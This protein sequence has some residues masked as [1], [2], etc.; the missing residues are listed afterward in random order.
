[1]PRFNELPGFRSTKG[2]AAA[3]L[4][5]C[6]WLASVASAN[7]TFIFPRVQFLWPPWGTY[8]ADVQHTGLSHYPAKALQ[9]VLWSYDIDPQQP[10][11]Q[12]VLAHYGSPV[13]TPANTVIFPVTT[14]LATSYEFR[15]V[16]GATGNTIWF[17]DTDYILPPCD[18]TPPVEGSVINRAGYAMPG[19]G[20]SI[21]YRANADQGASPTKQI[22][23]YGQA[24]HDANQAW[25]DANIKINTPI[26][27]DP[28]GNMWF[29][30]YV[31]GSN[32]TVTPT[33]PAGFPNLGRG[34]LARINTA[35]VGT[36]ISAT[37]AAGD[38]TVNF[39]ATACAP[40]L[41]ND[42]RSVYMGFVR[43]YNNS[44]GYLVKFDARTLAVQARAQPVSPHINP[45]T[46]QPYNVGFIVDSSA[47]PMVGPDG[48]VYMGVFGLGG[49]SADYRESH[50]WMLHYDADLNPKGAIG[51]FGW[52]DTA[53][54][55]PSSIVPQYTGTSPYLILT[56]YNNYKWSDFWTTPV[57][58]G[59]DGLNT[60]A[61]LDPFDPS[62]TDR[63]TGVSSMNP[64]LLV[65]GITPDDPAVPGSV[66]EW[67][68]NSAAI[69]P[70]NKTAIVNSEDG[71]CY[72][73]DFTSNTLQP[74]SLSGTGILL[75]SPTGEAYTP[76]VIGPNGTVY[77]I[78]DHKLYAIGPLP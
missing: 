38:T 35:N 41:S 69:D 58:P 54:I 11:G 30:Y 45:S 8:G 37:D 23:F 77:A 60:V 52:D 53:T 71:H 73:W 68:I 55:V 40:V 25:A 34:G 72:T 1:M 16:D 21:Y 2:A 5:F 75:N 49:F 6:L 70:F 9:Q 46:G 27:A 26:L 39:A 33:Y 28:R 56:K 31:G 78:N 24:N 47:C 17:F 10:A 13:I 42:V 66:R 29:G 48:D 15:A 43:A 4:A 50:G 65:Y 76:T 74:V 63:Q 36:W 19:V 64:V 44:T 67:C 3:C 14:Q 22:F 7:A 32:P 61:L 62:G 59:A 12:E 18:W 51:A 20:G 57:D